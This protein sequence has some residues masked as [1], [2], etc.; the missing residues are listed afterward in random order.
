MAKRAFPASVL[1]VLAAACVDP[2]APIVDGVQVELTP[3]G[4]LAQNHRSDTIY[5]QAIERVIAARVD[6]APCLGDGP[7][8]HIDPGGSKTIPYAQLMW[9]IDG[10]EEALFYWW[11]RIPDGTGRSRPDSIRV[12]LTRR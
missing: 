10:S 2:S 4:L 12:I 8:P 9:G 7:C 11:L 6:W 3:D 5:Y 1:L